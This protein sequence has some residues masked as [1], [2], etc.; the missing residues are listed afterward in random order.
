MEKTT[1]Y[2]IKNER[3]QYY[4]YTVQKID[5]RGFEYFY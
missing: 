5:G 2:S 3:G 4:G 1:K